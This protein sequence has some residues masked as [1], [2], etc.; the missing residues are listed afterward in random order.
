ML[1][2]SEQGLI[3][4]GEWEQKGYI[5][6]AFDRAKVIENTAKRPV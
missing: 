3:N 2:L 1:K 4:R 6:P 5:L